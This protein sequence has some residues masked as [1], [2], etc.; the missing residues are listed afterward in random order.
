MFFAIETA[1]P[2][3]NRHLITLLKIS[4]LLLFYLISGQVQAHIEYYDLNQGQ[5]ISDLTS[6]G[7]A[8]STSEFGSNPSVSALS[9]VNT[10]SDRPLI[11]PVF[12]MPAIKSIPA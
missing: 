11:D 7:K 5:Q 12:G 2:A 6:N 8:A 3:A 4:A 9:G 10:L 1:L